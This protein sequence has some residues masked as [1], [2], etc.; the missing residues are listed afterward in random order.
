MVHLFPKGSFALDYFSF[1]RLYS[2]VPPS[3]GR[4][5][6]HHGPLLPFELELTL[7]FP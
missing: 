7:K 2:P 4:Q 6:V 5:V 1:P 3:R